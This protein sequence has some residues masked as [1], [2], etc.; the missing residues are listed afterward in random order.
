MECFCKQEAMA[1]C[2]APSKEQ[3][4]NCY[5]YQKASYENRCM[6]FIMDAYCDNVE[7]QRE[8]KYVE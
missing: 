7:A 3:Q 2:I 4:T 6:Y 5:F 1:I 8:V